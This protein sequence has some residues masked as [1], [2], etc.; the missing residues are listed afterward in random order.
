MNHAGKPLKHFLPADPDLSSP[1]RLFAPGLGD[2]K[3]GM[4][5]ADLSSPERLEMPQDA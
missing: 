1:W 5:E 2:V 4:L 3:A